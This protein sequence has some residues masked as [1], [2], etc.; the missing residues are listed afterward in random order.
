MKK[1]RTEESGWFFTELI[2][3]CERLLDTHTVKSFDSGLWYFAADKVQ[4]LAVH[5]II[6]VL[7]MN[8]CAFLYIA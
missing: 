8:S 4:L 2:E 1:Q 7:M 3:F 5:M 6:M